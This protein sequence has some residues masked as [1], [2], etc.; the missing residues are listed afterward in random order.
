MRV[1]STSTNR[2]VTSIPMVGLIPGG[3]AFSPS[4]NYLYVAAYKVS[5]NTV[6]SVVVVISTINNAI[7]K[8]IPVGNNP[9]RL[10][11]ASSTNDIYVTNAGDNTVS[12]IDTSTDTVV[13][14]IPVGH[15]PSGIAFDSSNKEIY[16]ANYSDNTVT[17]ISTQG[18][19][20]PIIFLP[21]LG[22]PC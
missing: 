22:G 19:H 16:V 12:V 15:K 14:T 13:D 2:I 5:Q 8:T 10:A 20:L 3:I 9:Y 17:V 1:I 7:V 4:N 21:G 6:T 11:F 18:K